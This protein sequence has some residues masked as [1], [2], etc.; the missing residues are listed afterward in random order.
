[1]NLHKALGISTARAERLDEKFGVIVEALKKG[2][3]FT[4]LNL[5]QE[6]TKLA[7]TQKEIAYCGYCACNDFH[8]QTLL[9]NYSDKQLN[10]LLKLL[11]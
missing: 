6:F 8:L 1:M 2:K 5:L 9:S 11:K 4:N 7:K 3:R 10:K